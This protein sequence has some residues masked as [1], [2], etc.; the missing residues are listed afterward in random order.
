MARPLKP[1]DA[2]QVYRMARIGCTND[3]IAVLCDVST[4][5]IESRFLS[6]IKKGREKCKMS[7]RRLQL[8]IAHQGNPAMAIWL[9]KQM[10]K[11][12]DKVY[13]INVGGLTDEQLEAIANGADPYTVAGSGSGRTGKTPQSESALVN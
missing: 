2:K 5:T 13:N 11:Q 9:G 6:V 4:T 12:T 8:K 1:V 10:L 7:L 3:E